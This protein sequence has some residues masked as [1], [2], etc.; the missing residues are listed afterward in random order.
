[1]LVQ[2]NMINVNSGYKPVTFEKTENAPREKE[3]PTIEKKEEESASI[4]LTD[5]SKR[6][7]ETHNAEKDEETS[8][9]A[10]GTAQANILRNPAQ[11]IKAQA[12]QDPATVA[13]LLM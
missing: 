1:M 5:A 12:N 9:D 6:M 8:A 10:V 2:N 13:S 3:A 11:A 4:S 7:N